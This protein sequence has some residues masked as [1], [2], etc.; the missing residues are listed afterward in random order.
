MNEN[1]H[2]TNYTLQK[3]SNKGAKKLKICV[4]IKVYLAFF[5]RYRLLSSFLQYIH[6]SFRLIAVCK[7]AYIATRKKNRNANSKQ[8]VKRMF[9]KC[10]LIKPRESERERKLR[11]K[12]RK[13]LF[14]NAK[15]IC[16]HTFFKLCNFNEKKTNLFCLTKK[17]NEIEKYK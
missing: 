15:L 2:L 14:L 6:F 1:V 17:K 12:E 5:V 3:Y 16:V 10:K 9:A 4:F 7:I 11:K 8:F 13:K